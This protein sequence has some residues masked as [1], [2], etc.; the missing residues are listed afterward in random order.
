MVDQ[1]ENTVAHQGFTAGEQHHLH[2]A[3][4]QIIQ[5]R[6]PLLEGELVAD[7]AIAGGV[8]VTA[9]QVAALCGVP[10]HHPT[11]S[12]ELTGT[13]SD[14]IALFGAIAGQT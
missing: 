6:A 1:V 12:R 4:G 3:G 10:Y 7:G 9:A 2:P 5:H 14:A 13:V 11:E 8:A